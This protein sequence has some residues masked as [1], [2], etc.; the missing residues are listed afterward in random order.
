MLK[1]CVICHHIGK[2]Y[3]DFKMQDFLIFGV[4]LAQYIY[5]MHRNLCPSCE[6]RNTMIPVESPRAQKLIKEYDLVIPDISEVEERKRPKF[7]WE[8]S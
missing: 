1:L 5:A 4:Q 7:P 3:N 6:N 8:T 2:P